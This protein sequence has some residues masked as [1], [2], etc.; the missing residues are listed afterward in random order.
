MAQLLMRRPHLR[1][2]PS[3]RPLPDGYRI[4]EYA[5]MDDLPALLATLQEAF[6]EPWDEARARRELLDVPGVKAIYVI[7]HGGAVV[8]TTSS[9]YVSDLYPGAGYVHWVAVANAHLRRG[10]AAVLLNRVLHDFIERDYHDA[11]LETDD[12]RLPA[13][14]AY[15]R[16]GFLPVYD[17]RSES[18]RERWS[19]IFQQIFAR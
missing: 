10:L 4:R 8:G 15:L 9:K 5:G 7:D 6:F 18:H 1:D 13:I 14:S 17:V 3:V 19:A 11:V 16:F 2:L 12:H